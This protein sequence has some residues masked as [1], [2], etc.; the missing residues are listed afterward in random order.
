M[1]TIAG[2]TNPSGSRR[3][4]FFAVGVLA[5][6]ALGAGLMMLL[7]PRA[8]AEARRTVADSAR[9]FGEAGTEGYREARAH[10]ISAISDVTARGQ[11][12]RDDVADSVADGAREVVRVAVAAK[13][14][15]PLRQL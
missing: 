4:R 10:V 5:G 7:A 9:A 11:G 8:A 14:V 13:T 1:N 2:D 6:T 15:P 3:V 12:I